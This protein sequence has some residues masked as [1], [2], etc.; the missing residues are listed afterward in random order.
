[1][2][3]DLPSAVVNWFPDMVSVVSP[4]SPSASQ[5]NVPVYVPDRSV[6]SA[7]RLALDCAGVVVCAGICDASVCAGLVASAGVVP[8]VAV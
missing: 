3:P 1:M 7:A 4:L 8:G 2:R 5:L 6:C